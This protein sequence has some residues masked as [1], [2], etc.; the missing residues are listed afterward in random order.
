MPDSLD[1]VVLESLTD[2]FKSLPDVPFTPTSIHSESN[3][4]QQKILS[5]KQALSVLATASGA[6]S[7]ISESVD[8]RRALVNLAYEL[9]ID[10]DADF[11]SLLRSDD[12]K[13]IE[14]VFVI[15]GS[16]EW[17][18]TVLSLRGDLAQRFLDGAQGLLDRRQI[19]WG[20]EHKLHRMIR[21]LS[22]AS[23]RLPSSLFIQGISERGEH[24][25]YGG[26]FGDI[27]RASY[28]TKPVA[29][30]LMRHFLHG[31]EARKGQQKLLRE[32]LVWKELRHP[33]IL[34]F[35]GIDRETFPS[36]YCLVSPWMRNG[37]VLAFLQQHGHGQVI[38]FLSHIAEGLKYLHSL[39]IVHGDLRRRQ[40][41]SLMTHPPPA[42]A[43]FGLSA[44]SE[45]TASTSTRAG[46]V[47]WMAPELIDPD[48]FGTRFMR[49]PQ[50]DVFAFGC[51]C[52]EL[53]TGRP[54]FADYSEGAAML[55]LLAGERA[56]RPSGPPTMPRL[57]WQH[58]LSYWAQN[59]QDRPKTAVVAD[60]MTSVAT[61]AMAGYEELLESRESE[62]QDELDE[63]VL[64]ALA[65]NTLL[66]TRGDSFRV[67]GWPYG[68]P[69]DLVPNR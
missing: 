32:A 69:L 25:V 58:V 3:A 55:K 61:L 39:N 48:L 15:A 50:S 11:R 16:R 36:A 4:D 14:Q 53:Y 21:K 8:R 23:D 2:S 45:V 46:N 1:T 37:N 6:V 13:L 18:A 40:I 64:E 24:P 22:D 51:V 43:D 42:V 67:P 59:A 66:L 35:I 38:L 12:Q 26:G 20:Q 57:L 9:G 41:F 62:E 44:F 30:K 17:D 49:T 47:R 31:L 52:V 68:S 27:Y 33:N 60:N 54:P 7:V 19:V 56:P 65:V 5:A 28:N 34:P 29:L 63:A 10:Y